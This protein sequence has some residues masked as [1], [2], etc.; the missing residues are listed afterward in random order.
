MLTNT[1]A[2]AAFDL[3]ALVHGLREASGVKQKQEIAMIAQGLQKACPSLFPNGDD[4]AILPCADGFNLLAGEGFMDEFVK[5][6][7]WFAGWCGVMVN[8]S[9]ITAMGGRATAIVNALWGGQ[10]SET[11]AMVAGMAAA[12]K[13]YQVPIVGGHTN[14]RCE[15]PRLAV[16]IL[17]HT[18]HV[19]SS[20]EAQSGQIVVAAIDL[21]GA[22]QAPFNN[23]NAATSAPPERLRA[24]LEI[25]PTLAEKGL[26]TAAKDISQAGLL[27]TL[28]MM[29]ES[30][31]IGADIDLSAIPK[32]EHVEWSQW[33]QS[34]PS[35]G[36]VLTCDPKHL[37]DVLEHF[38]QRDIAAAAIGTL[39]SSQQC[40]VKQQHNRA[41]YW[42]LNT[43][44]LTQM[45]VDHA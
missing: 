25:L 41:L 13:A 32:P 26:A 12:S 33:L 39:N 11:K 5:A 44:A 23:W 21:R 34:F 1:H 8:V 28:V 42:D 22:Y 36:Y 17:G 20:F 6:D 2:S 31:S 35:F 10:D 27:G 24:D 29:L 43:T 19:L 30:S 7:P 45:G 4:A 16:S 3:E 9:D 15:Q 40:W 18:K 38:Q 14:L 37:T